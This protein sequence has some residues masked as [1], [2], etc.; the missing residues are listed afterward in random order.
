MDDDD[1]ATAGQSASAVNDSTRFL[2]SKVLL[3]PGFADVVFRTLCIPRV[4]TLAPSPGIDLVLLARHAAWS[5]SQ[6]RHRHLVTTAV[7]AWALVSLPLIALSLDLWVILAGGTVLGATMWA[8]ADQVRIDEMAVRTVDRGVIAEL[9]RGLVDEAHERRLAS[10]NQTNL[11][12][13]ASALDSDPFPGVGQ[14][15]DVNITP[16]L[17]ISKPKDEARPADELTAYELLDHLARN[18]PKHIRISLVNDSC[19]SDLVL[20][21]RGTHVRSV[22]E[23]LPDRLGPPLSRASSDLVRAF[24]NEPTGYARTYL[25]LQIVGHGG[26][27]VSTFHITAVNSPIGLSLDFALH[28]L[29]PMHATYGE[30]DRLPRSRRELARN[31]AGQGEHLRRFLYAPLWALRTTQMAKEAQQAAGLTPAQSAAV[32]KRDHYGT[33][34]G[35]REATSF[36]TEV[37]R[38]RQVDIDR[39]FNDLLAAIF[40]E[41]DVYL[42]SLNIDA[43][44][45]REKRSVIVQNIVNAYHQMINGPYHEGIRAN[46]INVG[47]NLN[48]DIRDFPNLRKSSN[49]GEGGAGE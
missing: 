2:C 10:V 7:L 3:D 43:S 26:A 15:V 16:T 23:L 25:R 45:W 8:V 17:D 14:R 49:P 9:G 33:Y 46:N 28:V 41:L 18:V 24:T 47:G 29:R 30:A 32:G 35:L 22:P 21:V 39:Q 37:S 12:I 20:Y 36:R 48:A 5:L 34:F 38:N 40:R 11:N 42:G 44:E 1:A 6:R 4:R 13:Y 27:V 19:R 31:L